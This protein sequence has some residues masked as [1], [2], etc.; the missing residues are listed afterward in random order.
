MKNKTK[1]K[2]ENCKKKIRIKNFFLNI[3]LPHNKKK[4]IKIYIK[5]EIK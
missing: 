3:R 2:Y 1:L 5:K 4:Y